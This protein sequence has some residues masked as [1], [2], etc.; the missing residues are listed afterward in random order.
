[1]NRTFINTVIFA[2]GGA[3]GVLVG[4]N[5][6]KEKYRKLAD[7]EIESV[8]ETW[9]RKY[10]PEQV[11]DEES[12]TVDKVAEMFEGHVSSEKPLKVMRREPSINY[13]AI[14]R[15]EQDE[16]YIPEE[17]A[18]AGGDERP[19][20]I[21]P[22]QFGEIEEY[23]QIELTYFADGVL[24]S[25]DTGR[26][27]EYVD[28]VVGEASLTTFGV[29]EEDSVYVRNDLTRCDYEILADERTYDDYLNTQPRSRGGR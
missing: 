6:S 11:A 25:T 29:Y 28:E 14:S 27:E 8:K 9:E 16:E 21:A 19:Y 20:V 10:K 26:R 5:I 23:S 4:I 2:A 3:I 15:P 12:M 1:M 13:N 22:D 7:E 24:I 18:P 17:K